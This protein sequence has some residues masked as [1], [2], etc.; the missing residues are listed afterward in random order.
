M[1]KTAAMMIIENKPLVAPT[2]AAMIER[3]H[4][5]TKPIPIASTVAPILLD[6][7]SNRPSECVAA[8]GKRAPHFWQSG[9]P[10]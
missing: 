9:M 3:I 10:K 5:E 1:L 7:R 2:I 6:I 4:I 8:P